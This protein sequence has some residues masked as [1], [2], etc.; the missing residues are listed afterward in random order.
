MPSYPAVYWPAGTYKKAAAAGIIGCRSSCLKD[1]DN[2]RLS[3][4]VFA[5][6]TDT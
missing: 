5:L 6:T 3:K 4:P 1:T 2:N